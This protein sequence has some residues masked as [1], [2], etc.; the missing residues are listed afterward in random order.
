MDLPGDFGGG[1]SSD[2][3][4][5][6]SAE[7]F[8]VE[9]RDEILDIATVLTLCDAKPEMLLIAL[10][11]MGNDLR[12]SIRE[13][14]E[15]TRALLKTNV[16][17]V[18]EFIARR[19]S[20]R[21][22]I[23]AQREKKRALTTTLAEHDQNIAR[24][25]GEIAKARK[26]EQARRLKEELDA[27]AEEHKRSLQEIRDTAARDDEAGKARWNEGA[28][29]R[30]EE[31]TRLESNAAGLRTVVAESSKRTAALNE[32][33]V[34]YRVA[35][36]LS[37]LGY[38]SVAA[39]GTMW[40]L[41]V[42]NDAA[43]DIKGV[44]NSVKAFT[45]SLA[46]TPVVRYSLAALVLFLSLAAILGVA[47]A[48]DWLLGRRFKP[49]TS[50]RQEP[51]RLSVRL[52][53]TSISRRSYIQ[54]SGMVPFA[55]AGGLI[56]AFVSV[57]STAV[58]TQI[59]NLL[60]TIAQTFIGSAIALLATAAFLMYAVK[61]IEPRLRAGKPALRAWEFAAPPLALLIAVAVAMIAPKPTRIVWGGW[62]LFMLCS[63][64]A[65]AYGVI[66]DGIYAEAQWAKGALR[67]VEEKMNSLLSRPDDGRRAE[68]ER[69]AAALV[70][71]YTA[72]RVWLEQTARAQRLGI[73]VMNR[74]AQQRLANATRNLTT[75]TEESTGVIQ[76]AKQ[77]VVRI[78]KNV[79]V[80]AGPKADT[81][82]P[83]RWE[84]IDIEVAPD[85]V[86]KIAS[87]RVQQAA[88]QAEMDDLQAS[89]AENVAMSTWEAIEELRTKQANLAGAIAQSEAKDRASQALTAKAETELIERV[90]AAIASAKQLCGP[91]GSVAE[92][93]TSAI[94]PKDQPPSDPA[95]PPPGPP[96]PPPLPQ[97]PPPPVSM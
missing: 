17:A 96:P 12:A 11:S 57:T 1:V 4:D 21:T 2:I 83:A 75:I 37:W 52:T 84:P 59:E 45:Q 67:V 35:R 3:P 39:T 81:A 38:A 62:T 54:L 88:V 31:L 7:R 26:A 14:S 68:T 50:E 58:P 51:E 30:K 41:I 40:A 16:A 73:P 44:L 72:D 53:P 80:F 48:V 8:P 74:K 94:S 61:W 32:G 66:Y 20:L 36:F 82:D 60:P 27:L 56:L 90:R 19:V 92:E 79:R 43:D 28:P 77:A 22:E 87:A 70:A 18:I 85:E 24:L 95:P 34:T 47:F 63:S 71:R 97:L 42:K 5:G 33:L 9:N 46:S 65:L 64:L 10:Q 29:R 23:T 86:M 89:I 55:F 76:R 78:L 13:T 25:E 93:A 15:S 49:W 69:L 91:F 6:R